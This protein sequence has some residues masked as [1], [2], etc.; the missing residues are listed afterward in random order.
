M[1]V[2][3]T[4]H[5][6]GRQHVQKY[7]V[8]PGEEARADEPAPRQQRVG[9]PRPPGMSDKDWA[10]ERERRRIKNDYVRQWRAKRKEQGL[11][12][13]PG[14]PPPPLPQPIPPGPPPEK[15]PEEDERVRK[16]REY[17]KRWREKQRLL[18][19]QGKPP[20]KLPEKPEPERPRKPGELK[21]WTRNL[22][23]TNA[24]NWMRLNSGTLRELGNDLVAQFKTT[25]PD[26]QP[27]GVTGVEPAR[28]PRSIAG[29]YT[30]SVWKRGTVELRSDIVRNL[31]AQVRAGGVVTPVGGDAIRI[32]QRDA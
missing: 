20:E 4:V 10:A 13:K 25:P 26:V 32:D 6:L 22:I 28:M 12:K 8:R 19:Q 3:K 15:E 9:K 30:S 7:W 14:D 2:E 21:D 23:K 16:R 5:R 27:Y 24:R 29:R 11:L 1:L 17:V 18:K 31:V